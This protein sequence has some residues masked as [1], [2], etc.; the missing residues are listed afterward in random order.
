MAIDLAEGGRVALNL[1]GVAREEVPRGACV[2]LSN[3]DTPGT[4]E[5]YAGADECRELLVARRISCNSAKRT[6]ARELLVI[7][8]PAQS[9]AA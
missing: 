2:V 6:P 8:R 4:R 5:L 1:A 9:T 3:H 7:F